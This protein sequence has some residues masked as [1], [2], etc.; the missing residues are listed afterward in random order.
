MNLHVLMVGKKHATFDMFTKSNIIYLGLVFFPLLVFLAIGYFIIPIQADFIRETC[1]FIITTGFFYCLVFVFPKRLKPSFSFVAALILSFLLL[2]KLSFYQLYQTKL[3]ASALFVIF[4]TNAEETAG[5]LKVYIN[6]FVVFLAVLFVL[7]L[8]AFSLRVWKRGNVLE[9]KLFNKYPYFTKLFFLCGAVLCGYLIQ[10]KFSDYNILYTAKTSFEEYKATKKLLRQ[11]LAKPTS[12][13]LT[14]VEASENSPEIAV[15][16]IGE[17][18][19]REHM[20]LYGYYRKNNPNLTAMRD[21]LIVFENTI[22]PHVHTITAI[23]EIMTLQ[24][25]ER[26][27]V[28]NNAS[29]IQLANEAGYKTYWLSNQQPVGFFSSICTLIGYAADEKKFL[30]TNAYNRISYDEVLLPALDSALADA[31]PK[32]KMIFLHLMGSHLGYAERYP[33]AFEK[34]TDKPRSKYDH[35]KA[36]HLINAYDNS[37]LYNDYIVKEII[38]RVRKEN[39]ASYV[40]YFSDHGDDVYDTWDNAG[41]NE[42]LGTDPMYE[43][44]FFVWLS[45][46]YQK[47][48]QLKTSV[49]EIEKRKYML[50]DFIHTFAE[51]TQIGFDGFEEEESIFSAKYEPGPRIIKDTIDY[52]LR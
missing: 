23:G 2:L 47:D 3:S 34:F 28:K 43:V 31:T 21:E 46:E 33:P 19:S 42:Y 5:F 9:I 7:Y 32:N 14:G 44:P 45:E 38:E 30:N 29:V 35:P 27:E 4:E 1:N 48:Y 52:D 13:Y 10:W 37:I 36:V 25:A 20:G 6:A 22:T 50:D 8:L 40:L 39:A 26:P 16:V 49:A 41:H 24:S 11:Q 51:L 15:V 17:S 12:E 18:T